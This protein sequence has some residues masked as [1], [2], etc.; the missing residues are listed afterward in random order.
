MRRPGLRAWPTAIVR[1]GTYATLPVAADKNEPTAKAL[2]SLHSP[3]G[4]EFWRKVPRWAD[5]S[6][7]KFISQRWSSKETVNGEAQLHKFLK[8]VVPDEIPLDRAGSK[9]QSKDAFLKDVLEGVRAATMAVRITPYLLS[10]VNWQ[11]PR[12]DPIFRQF[13]VL[14]S[15][16]LPDPPCLQLDSL[17]EHDDEAAPGFIHRYHDKGLFL[18]T[19]VC[20]TYCAGCTRA[21]GVGGDTCALTKKQNFLNPSN[22][23]WDKIFEYIEATPQLQDIVL[24][25]GDTWALTPDMIQRLGERLISIPHIKRFRY[26]SKGMCVSPGRMLDP[27]DGWIDALVDVTHKARKANK[28]VALHTHFNHPDEISWITRAAARR[29]FEAH[30]TVRCQTVLINGVN[31][32]AETLSRLIRSLADMHI[33]PYYV[34]QFDMVPN[35]EHLR[36]PL[37]TILDLEEQVRGSIAGFMMPQFVVDLPGGGGKRLS[38]SFR[39]YNRET[40][41]STFVAP[42]VTEGSSRGAGKPKVFRYYDPMHRHQ[43]QL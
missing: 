32:N 31:N 26:A 37:Q 11:D 6:P 35:S 17:R 9:V 14:K 15:N 4:D 34:Y 24:S 30:V 27:N 36:T 43:G 2:Q 33:Q 22:K 28:A 20:P 39:E 10:R 3:G 16:L 23:R 41:V 12:N 38:N 8:E 19:S 21:H 5:V 42:A 13:V 7:E 40:G 18:T 1:R 29:L 25:G